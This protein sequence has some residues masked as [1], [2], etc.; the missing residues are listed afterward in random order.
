MLKMT[1]NVTLIGQSMIEDK[2]AVY[3]SASISAD[4]DGGISI[5][6]TITHHELY[7]ANKTEARKDMSDFENKVYDTQDEIQAESQAEM[8][9]L[10][11]ED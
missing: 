9:V 8:E 5:N 4:K 6:K 10:E 11:I 1:K 2:Q 3:M 7:N